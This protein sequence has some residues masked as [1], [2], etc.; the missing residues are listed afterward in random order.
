MSFTDQE[1]Y[2]STNRHRSWFGE[3]EEFRFRQ[4]ELLVEVGYPKGNEQQAA[5]E[6]IGAQEGHMSWRC[7]FEDNRHKEVVGI[8]KRVD[9]K[10]A[11]PQRK[12]D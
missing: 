8:D 1:N 2:S 9:N 5:E 6:E 12:K 10:R 7:K 4:N 11:N 3:D